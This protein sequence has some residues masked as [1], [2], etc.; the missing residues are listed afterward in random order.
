MALVTDIVTPRRGSRA[1]VLHLD[2]AE[3]RTTSSDVVKDLS[4]RVGHVEPIEDL[5][6]RLDGAETSHAR[7][8]ALALLAYRDRSAFEL[9]SRLV[10]DGYPAEAASTT[11]HTLVESGLVDD[12]RFAASLAHVL[13]D[14][15]GYGKHRAHSEM[16]S[17]GVPDEIAQAAIEEVLPVEREIDNAREL[18]RTLIAR[19]GP[20]VNRLA[21]RLARKG[22]SASVALGIARETVEAYGG[23]DDTLDLP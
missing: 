18:A 20:D 17:K 13:V 22:Y 2:H 11:V 19:T 7:E 12:E 8:R 4:L 15:R 23:E 3:W 16:R 10:E 5:S 1:R 21:A 9:R 14:V 6:Q